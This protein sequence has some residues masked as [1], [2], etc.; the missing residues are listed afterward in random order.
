M[1]WNFWTNL[2]KIL[3]FLFSRVFFVYMRQYSPLSGSRKRVVLCRFF[4]YMHP[5][6]STKIYEN[7]ATLIERP[8]RKLNRSVGISVRMEKMTKIK[9][10]YT[11]PSPCLGSRKKNAGSIRFCSCS[12]GTPVDAIGFASS[13]YASKPPVLKSARADPY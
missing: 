12:P 6:E 9:I 5:H 1:G 13:R 4:F 8:K 11:R 10:C 2:R 7:R 3:C